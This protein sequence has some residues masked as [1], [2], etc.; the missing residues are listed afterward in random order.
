M[1]DYGNMECAWSGFYKYVMCECSYAIPYGIAFI[2]ISCVWVCENGS[3][4]CACVVAD[5]LFCFSSIY[6]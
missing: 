1:R 5:S 4:F 6:R 3:P 2:V